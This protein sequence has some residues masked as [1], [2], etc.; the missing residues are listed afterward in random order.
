M[1]GSQRG[2]RLLQIG[3]PRR[4]R[5]PENRSPPAPGRRP[6]S[7]FRIRPCWRRGR[8][9]S[10]S[11]PARRSATRPRLRRPSKCTG[12]VELADTPTSGSGSATVTPGK[13]VGTAISSCRSVASP[14]FDERGGQHDHI[15]RRAARH[16]RRH[17]VE[18][19]PAGSRFGREHRLA[20]V[21][22]A[23]REMRDADRG[24]QLAARQPRQQPLLERFVLAPSIRRHAP[25]RCVM[26][27][28]V[29]RHAALSAR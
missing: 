29:V 1:L 3:T 8:W 18:P 24:K 27:N 7:K 23:G 6:A 10:H 4:L 2:R 22:P 12:P 25:V 19:K 28:V 26:M 21:P 9:P 5:R 17:A 20:Q 11:A 14:S 15:G 16:P 13:S